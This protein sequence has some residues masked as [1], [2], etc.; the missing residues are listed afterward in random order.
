MLSTVR[1]QRSG[2][3]PS[4]WSL[5]EKKSSAE[6]WRAKSQASARG[7]AP[8]PPLRGRAEKK[9]STEYVV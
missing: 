3:S 7:W 5:T 9:A 2:V 8:S 4:A 6:Q 1:V